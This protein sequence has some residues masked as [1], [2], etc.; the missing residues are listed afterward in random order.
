MFVELI[1]Q[2]ERDVLFAYL[3]YCNQQ[4]LHWVFNI[5]WVCSNESNKIKIAAFLFRKIHYYIYILK[6]L[7]GDY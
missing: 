3:K 6:F 7:A 2:Y 4:Y 5:F 1:F